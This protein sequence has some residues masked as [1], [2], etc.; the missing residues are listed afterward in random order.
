MSIELRDFKQA[1]YLKKVT[2][3]LTYDLEFLT[4]KQFRMAGR[5]Y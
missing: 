2:D 1:L 4:S 5:K 3:R